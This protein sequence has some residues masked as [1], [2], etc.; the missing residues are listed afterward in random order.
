[1]SSTITNIAA[2]DSLH[3][4]TDRM[5]KVTA[6]VGV[7]GEFTTPLEVRRL[8][9]CRFFC[10]LACRRLHWTEYCAIQWM[11]CKRLLYGV[12]LS[13]CL[14][15]TYTRPLLRCSHVSVLTI[16]SLRRC[17][18]NKFASLK[19]QASSVFWKWKSQRINNVGHVTSCVSDLEC[20]RAAGQIAREFDCERLTW[21]CSPTSGHNCELLVLAGIIDLC[22]V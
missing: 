3:S 20:V 5:R 22:A 4:N 9:F 2:S 14:F 16:V 1:M 17:N 12:T 15:I 11:R 7:E 19:G 8:D 6:H 21:R 18:L 10:P 13:E